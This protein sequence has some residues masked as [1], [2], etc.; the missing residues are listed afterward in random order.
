M[1]ELRE[2]LSRRAALLLL[3]ELKDLYRRLGGYGSQLLPEKSVSKANTSGQSQTP[4]STQHSVGCF[5]EFPV[6][7]VLL[8]DA[9]LNRLEELV[10]CVLLEIQH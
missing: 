4:R 1:R 6:Q 7:S 5:F 2:G 9:I 10:E 8:V 3:F